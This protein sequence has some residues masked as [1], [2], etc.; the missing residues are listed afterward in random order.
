MK[1]KKMLAMLV[2]LS[3]VAPITYAGVS[4]TLAHGSP[5]KHVITKEFVEPWKQ[6][7]EKAAGSDVS[8]KYFPSGQ[9]AKIKELLSAM[10][11]GVADV[12]PVPVGYSSDKLP[13]N[14]VSMLPGLGGSSEAIVS[15]YWKSL[16]NDL[17]A[18]EFA[19]NGI[20]PI[21]V[22]A[23]PP[24]QIVSTSKKIKTPEQFG[25]KVIRS[26]GGAMDLIIK[27]LGGSPAT[28]SIGDTYVAL[29]R[30]TADATISALASVDG[31][32]LQELAKSIS[33]NGSFGTFVNVLAVRQAK[34][35]EMD[36]GLKKIFKDCG[37][38]IQFQSARN[39]DNAGSD[40]AKKFAGAGVEM[41]QFSPDQ[42][43]E[44]SGKLG[45]VHQD[46]TD[47]LNGRGLKADDV[48]KAYKA[49]F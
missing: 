21:S 46:W 11:K 20:V 8:F 25:G 15:A 42:L 41:F 10:D 32:K 30:G 36:S 40:L 27:S 14:G 29:Q 28:I 24:Y 44:M 49:S 5:A 47:R 23:F 45:A 18:K 16:S 34:W 9:L 35:D 2:G 48:L 6:C 19:A 22:M 31:Y 3:M 13:L 7:V 43:K 39:L 17:L 37:S 33:T 4:I 1:N 38:K 26:A 12:T